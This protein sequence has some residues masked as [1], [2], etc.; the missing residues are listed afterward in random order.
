MKESQNRL[1]QENI[2][3]HRHQGRY[4]SLLEGGGFFIFRINCN[5]VYKIFNGVKK[6]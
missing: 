4:L 1:K 3:M 6:F 5:F 2:F